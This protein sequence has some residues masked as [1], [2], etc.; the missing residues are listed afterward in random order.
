MEDHR[1]Q[2]NQLNPLDFHVGRRLPDNGHSTGR[3]SVRRR[4]LRVHAQRFHVREVA[5]DDTNHNEQREYQPI[6]SNNSAYPKRA[7]RARVKR[8]QERR[9][10]AGYLRHI[11]SSTN[12]VAAIDVPVMSTTI[13]NF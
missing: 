11:T 6:S 1:R 9:D 4:H 5:R 13:R 8:V 12:G 10:T 7:A 3:G 2:R